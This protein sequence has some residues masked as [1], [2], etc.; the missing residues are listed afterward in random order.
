MMSEPKEQVN[1]PGPEP[2]AERQRQVEA[3]AEDY[4]E[5]LLAGETPDRQAFLAEHSDLADLVGPRLELVELMHRVAR[6]QRPV[7]GETA[8]LTPPGKPAERVLRMKCPHCGNGIQLVEPIDGEVTCGSCGSSFHVDARATTTYN[9]AALPRSIGKFEVLEQ[10]GRGAFGTVYKARDPEL[11]RIVAVKVPRTGSFATIEEEERFLREARAAAQLSHP[12][13]VPVLEIAHDR[14]VP[15]I[16]SEYVEGLTLADVLT[17]RR[18]GFR[19][20]AEMTAAVAD[21]LDYAHR[22]KIVHRDIK[23]SN[24]LLDAAGRPHITD[25][26]LARRGEG[27]ITVTLD[28]QILGTPAYMAP[29]QAAGD[30]QHVDARSDVYSLGVVLYELLT[31]E[32]PFR[33][34][35]RMLLHQVIHDEPRPPRSLNDRVPRDLETICLKAMAK[36]TGRRYGSAMEMAEDLRRFL[37]G[38]PIRARR[39]GRMEKLIRW[40]RRNPVVSALSSAV[41]LLL[42]AVAVG[43]FIFVV[44]ERRLN[45]DLADALDTA[46]RNHREAELRAA[47]AA[48][49]LDLKHCEGGEIEYGVLRLARTLAELPPHA[50]ELRQCVEMNLL[51]WAQE[52]R[53]LGPTFRYDGAETKWELSPDGLTVLTGGADGT[54][55]L[56]DA[57]TGEVRATLRGHR[58]GINSV[59]FSQNGRVAM[60]VGE[61]G[62]VRLWDAKSGE[63]RSV[64]S[65]GQRASQ[66]VLLSPDA[67]RLLTIVSDSFILNDSSADRR[68][69]SEVLLWDGPTG[70]RIAALAGH[71]GQV[72]AAAFSADGKTVLTGG[73]DKTARLWSAEDGRGIGTLE[74]SAWPISAVAFNSDATLAAAYSPSDPN[75]SAHIQLWD[76]A[77]RIRVCPP[78]PTTNSG[79]GAF[80][81]V[82]REVVASE[83]AVEDGTYRV[84]LYVKGMDHEITGRINTR[85]SGECQADDEYA[86]DSQGSVYQLPAGTRRQPPVGHRFHPAAARFAALKRF[87]SV[88]GA[89]TDLL[90][91]KVIGKAVRYGSIKWVPDQ[92]TF[93]AQNWSSPFYIRFP[94]S[95]LDPE[96]AR[97]FAEVVT[98]FKLDPDGTIQPLKEAEWEERRRKLIEPLAQH[99]AP[100]LISRLAADRWYWLRRQEDRANPNDG[101]AAWEKEL[102]WLDPLVAVEPTWQNYDRRAEKRFN[103]NRWVEAAQDMLEAG[104]LAGEGYWH[105]KMLPFVGDMLVH[106]LLL[107][108]TGTREKYQLALRLAEKLSDAIPED[109]ERR[110]QLAIA[111]YRVG[112]YADALSAL[113]PSEREWDKAIASLVGQFLLF[114]RRAAFLDMRNTVDQDVWVAMG[115]LAMTHHRLGHRERAQAALADLRSFGKLVVDFKLEGGFIR[116][117]PWEEDDQYR[118]VLREAETL[119]EGK[120]QPGK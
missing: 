115:F 20:A 85:G 108:E 3:L 117:R 56:W 63:A 23:P 33:G 40:A 61:D 48:V 64:I 113:E 53:P 7:D 60:T 102:K 78:C 112:N 14:G 116:P 18:P 73:S 50:T 69:K 104:R 65:V 99:S 95:P 16:V 41:A 39:V 101:S 94:S 82:G 45:H 29:E 88:N 83:S 98:C 32:L 77:R 36:T 15:Y 4:L 76:T 21:A 28:G 1:P 9:R 81:F 70:K 89:L 106:N 75:H 2:Q 54:A 59:A 55:R 52:I 66:E 42:A 44:T 96:I 38:E 46:E 62:T 35:Q 90:T 22:Q 92:Q 13:I 17:A 5:R 25:F 105:R 110:I 57:F 109:R 27:E 91:E 107:P 100:P 12:G 84:A 80:R 34:N 67:S 6:A 103:L 79:Q 86:L 10:L 19:Q 71:T 30:Q 43:E 120:P 47:S 37:N 87:L 93:L 58:G 68:S 111:H 114:G 74:G 31:G 97:L 26:G 49:D 8:S 118:A 24:L 11:Q 119:I 51:A 72:N